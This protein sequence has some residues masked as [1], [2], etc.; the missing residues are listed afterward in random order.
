MPRNASCLLRG[1]AVDEGNKILYR[2]LR[3]RRVPAAKVDEQ[4]AA[5]M[6]KIR[7]HKLFEPDRTNPAF[8]NNF[9]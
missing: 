2:T 6:S 8:R 3:V 9:V 5:G 7:R 1:R 4:A